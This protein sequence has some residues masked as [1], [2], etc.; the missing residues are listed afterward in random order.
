[1]YPKKETQTNVAY[2]TLGLSNVTI[3]GM[4][5]FQT[6]TCTAFEFAYVSFI[7]AARALYGQWDT[8]HDILSDSPHRGT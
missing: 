5:N 7:V 3:L 2:K 8:L 4:S 6:K 1:M